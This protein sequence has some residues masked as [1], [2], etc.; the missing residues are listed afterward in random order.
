MLA[1]SIK[2]PFASLIIGG[3]KPLEIRTW[4]TN[5]RGPVLIVA[6]QK[7][8]PAYKKLSSTDT[9]TV[10]WW[11]TAFSVGHTEHSVTYEGFKL[12]VLHQ[13]LTFQREVVIGV[14]DL[15][16]VRPMV[17]ADEP[18]ALCPFDESLFAW[19]FENP[20]LLPPTP[21]KGKLNLFN[22]DP[23]TIEGL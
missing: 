5:Y 21:L 23:K 1:L 16:N 18:K 17:E 11:N 13:P 4:K 10:L 8:H 6:G 22:V 12:W 7:F 14:A 2:Q 9:T 3:V 15:V 20:R 19:E